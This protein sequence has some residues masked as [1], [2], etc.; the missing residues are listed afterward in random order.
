MT[1]PKY[2]LYQ[3]NP[4]D[5]EDLQQGDI[6]ENNEEIRTIIKQFYPLISDSE[7]ST[8]IVITQS[9]DLVRRDNKP[10]KSKYVNLAPIQPL[11]NVFLSLFD[12]VYGHFKITDRL[13][14]SKGKSK[15]AELIESICNQ[16]A[17]AL[18]IFFLQANTDVKIPEDSVALLP[19][20]FAVSS[21][22]CYDKLVK[23]RSGRLNIAFQS[24]LGW[25]VGN[26]YSRVAAPDFPKSNREEVQRDLLDKK[27]ENLPR[28]IDKKQLKILGQEPNNLRKDQIEALLLQYDPKA[29]VKEAIKHV[30]DTVKG[31]IEEVP[32]A[33]LQEIESK[34]STK[35]EFELLFR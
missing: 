30:L 29:P 17:W 35:L 2:S 3:D 32:A 12:R 4:P 19:V 9:C 14:S 10:C 16:N 15:A 34:L 7:Y 25:L 18:G 21:D 1:E 5:K 11:E 6:I 20:S 26:L 28:W 31:V 24:R 22:L 33:K 27:S 23:H 8:F 13:Y